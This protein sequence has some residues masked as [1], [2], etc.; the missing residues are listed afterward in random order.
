MAE[1]IHLTEPN[2]DEAVVATKGVV[3]VVLW[4]EWCGPC[5]A[6]APVLE[7]LVEASEDRRP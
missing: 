7:E 6:I 5:R 3:M 2:F 4:A 1:T